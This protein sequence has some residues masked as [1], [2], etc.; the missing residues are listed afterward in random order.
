MA[1]QSI[2]DKW[3]PAVDTMPRPTFDDA[4]SAS[5]WRAN[6]SARAH[7][8]APASALGSTEARTVD[9]EVRQG[10]WGR[11]MRDYWARR[12]DSVP[13][14]LTT[15]EAGALAGWVVYLGDSFDEGVGLAVGSP[16][17]FEQHG[18]VLL[19][20]GNHAE[21]SPAACAQLLG[22]LLAGTDPPFW[23]CDLLQEIVAKV[24]GHASEVEMLRIR[25]QALRLGCT[26][27]AV[28]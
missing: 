28:W 16:A 26:T 20:L 25:E 14:R 24:R 6:H 7:E 17:G 22:H 5:H 11:W 13:L 12:L 21:R 18:Q 3:P 1:F 4:S 10:Q 23:Q 15:E 19:E 8:H 27:A 9:A 2:P